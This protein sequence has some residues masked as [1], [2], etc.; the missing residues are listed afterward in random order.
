MP[1]APDAI[2][3]RMQKL[4]VLQKGTNIMEQNNP[5]SVSVLVKKLGLILSV[6]V[7]LLPVFFVPVSG[8]S[9]YVAKII[10]LATG[11]VAIFAVFLSSVL[12]TGTIEMPKA[13]FL[14]PIAALALVALISSLISGSISSSIVGLVFDL[15]T[16]GSI[17]MLVFAIFLTI[18]VVKSLGVV[19]R[20]F[21]S[22]VY[23][24]VFLAAYTLLSLLLALAPTSLPFLSR[25]PAFLAGSAIDMAIVFGAAVIFAL[26]MINMTEISKRFKIILSALMA[27]SLIFIGATNFTPVVVILGLISLVFLVYILSW[28]VGETNENGQNKKI[29]LSSLGVLVVSVVLLLGGSNIGEF[30]AKTLRIQTLEVRPNL[31]TTMDLSLSAWQKNFALGVGPNHFAEFW[32]ERKP[33]SINQTQFWNT[34]FYFGSGFVPT[35]AITTGLL[36]LLSVLA[37]LVLYVL[38]G[39]KAIFAQANSGRS[40]YLATTSFL[41]S[42]YLW[43]I[44]FFYAPSLTVLA[45]TFIFTGLFTATLVPQGIVG[46]WRIN[47]FANPKTNFLSVLSIVV[48]LIMSVAGGYLV[49]ERAIAATIFEKG[50][51]DYQK[52]GN[53]ALAKE[54]ISKSLSMAPN[55]VYWRGLAEVYLLDLNRILGSVTSQDQIT[56][57]IRVEVQNAI[58]GSVEA[59]KKATESNNKN[60]ANWFML[61]RVYEALAGN[62]I[63]GSLES[64]RAAYNEAAL[65]SPNNPSVPLALAR[66][67]AMSKNIALARE[68][69][70]KALNLKNNYTDA[71]YTLAQLEAAANNIPAAIRSVEAATVVEPNNSGLYFQ[72]GLL[73]YSERDFAGAALSFERAIVLVPDYANAKYYLGVSYYQTGKKTEAVK[74]FEDL[75]KGNPDNQ[76]VLFILSNMKA[77]KSLFPTA[78]IS[79]K[80]EP[81]VKD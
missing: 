71:F 73:K 60:F 4:E 17:L 39:V 67:E 19:D 7:F 50:I 59:A 52:S 57:S 21:M 30:L 63:E 24:S 53:I 34:D 45:L 49:W 62:G 27:F 48:L 69:I 41:V 10:L 51:I 78:Q 28:S 8:V 5:G 26:C 32:S 14:I 47:I 9:L 20:A 16:A 1:F 77:G 70:V 37:F 15:G 35:L 75:A 68:N 61:G 81:P 76:D 12:S 80:S 2:E 13:K 11:L 33:L 56:E 38:A 43:V 72:L 55:D 31:Q 23:A 25:M 64:A 29:S 18:F 58:A 65:R 6:L 40:R 44:L 36:G 22:F 79:D 54:S 74:I 46:L 66:L 42:F 3:V